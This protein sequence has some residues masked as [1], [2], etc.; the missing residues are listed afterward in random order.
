MKLSELR[1]FSIRQQTRIR[2]RIRNGMECVINEHGIAQVPGLNR[3]PDFNLEEELA[4]AGEF[5]LEPA[6]SLDP[7]RR[8]PCSREELAAFV[9]APDASAAG[10]EHE[11]E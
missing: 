7:S 1:R 9:G 5:L 8:R 3:V 4:T 2:F 11:D 6:G 10:Q